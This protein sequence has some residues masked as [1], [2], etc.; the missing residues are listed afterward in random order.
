[1]SVSSALEPNTNQ[2]NSEHSAEWKCIPKLVGKHLSIKLRVIVLFAPIV[3]SI[4]CEYFF[5][6]AP[7]NQNKITKK[8]NRLWIFCSSGDLCAPIKIYKLQRRRKGSSFFCSFATMQNIFRVK[9]FVH[10][11]R[12]LRSCTLLV[13]SA[14]LEKQWKYHNFKKN[15]RIV[16]QCLPQSC[17][18]LFAWFYFPVIKYCGEYKAKFCFGYLASADAIVCEFYSLTTQRKSLGY[19][20]VSYR[21]CPL[22]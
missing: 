2:S 15:N 21:W 10:A 17:P 7:K 8:V 11:W 19:C 3:F 1:M 22:Q 14:R 18:H 9:S 12:R 6:T 16:T 5:A 20:F 4:N 13:N